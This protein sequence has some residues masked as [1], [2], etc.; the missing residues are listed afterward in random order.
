M[1]TKQHLIDSAR[2]AVR[3]SYCPY[4]R[5]KIGAALST[6]DG[7]IFSGCNIENV[8]FGLSICAERVALFKAI[9]E[10]YSKFESIAIASVNNKPVFPCGACRQVLS[11]F[12]P[13][14]KIYV[15]NDNKIHDLRNLLPYS[16]DSIN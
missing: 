11:E 16:F 15:N 1:I 8:S 9:S 2:T 10:G 12:T 7:K 6:I 3:N 14:L 13:N 4:S 5:L